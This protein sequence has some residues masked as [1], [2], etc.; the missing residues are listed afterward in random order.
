MHPVKLLTVVSIVTIVEFNCLV[1]ITSMIF[2]TPLRAVF[3]HHWVPNGR[4]CRGDDAT[5]ES[6]RSSLPRLRKTPWLEFW[7]A[8]LLL[9]FYL[10]WRKYEG[11]SV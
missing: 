1:E 7:K 9:R 8:L 3:S 2:C 10:S 4:K 11:L 5:F 6:S